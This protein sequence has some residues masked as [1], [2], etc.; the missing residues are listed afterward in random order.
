[1]SE[2]DIGAVV[3]RDFADADV[4]AVCALLATYG[5]EPHERDPR[6]I[7][8]A[9]LRVV[10][11]DRAALPQWV[12]WAKLDW[13]DVMLAVH[14]THGTAWVVPFLAKGAS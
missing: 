2:A 12:E 11:G 8:L 10:N 14:Q 5:V 4:G 13:R 1:M 3:R 6:T 7:R 9:L